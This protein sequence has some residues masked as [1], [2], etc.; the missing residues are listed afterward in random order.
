MWMTCGLH[1][2]ELAGRTLRW[3]GD[4]T[5]LS[6]V[7]TLSFRNLG[8]PEE[9]KHFSRSGRWGLERVIQIAILNID[10]TETDR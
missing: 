3:Q 4:S 1:R 2:V 7:E 10:D 9:G 6:A 5:V 8:K